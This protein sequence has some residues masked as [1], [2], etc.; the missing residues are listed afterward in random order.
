MNYTAAGQCSQLIWFS[1]EM[2]NFLKKTQTIRNAPKFFFFFFFPFV[3]IHRTLPIEQTICQNHVIKSVVAIKAM[4]FHYTSV[5]LHFQINFVF[6]DAIRAH[7]R[8]SPLFSQCIQL[9]KC[10]YLNSFMCLFWMFLLYSAILP[11]SL[12]IV[13]VFSLNWKCQK[14]IKTTAKTRTERKSKK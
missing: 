5:Y 6:S 4:A 7:R 1:Y 12:S 13:D 11:I 9:N 14:W 10:K 3:L 8:C 2:L